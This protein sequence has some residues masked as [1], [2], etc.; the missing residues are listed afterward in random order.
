VTFTPD[1]RALV[2]G[3][4]KD[5]AARITPLGMSEKKQ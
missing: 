5:Y 2:T 4:E 3:H 1:G